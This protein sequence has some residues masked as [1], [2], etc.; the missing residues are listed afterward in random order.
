MVYET[1][2]V[3][4]E[5]KAFVWLQQFRRRMSTTQKFVARIAY[6]DVAAV[7]VAKLLRKYDFEIGDYDNY[8]TSAKNNRIFAIASVERAYDEGGIKRVD[9]LLY[10]LR[11]AWDGRAAALDRNI[12]KGL[13]KFMAGNAYG[14][15]V[16]AERLKDMD[17]YTLEV[18]A[19][20]VGHSR[21]LNTSDA[22][23]AVIG[24]LYNKKNL[25]AR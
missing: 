22:F 4:T 12:I 16:L 8:N 24:N 23:A 21:G 25:K 10:V 3:E 6:G 17:P 18:A 11:E 19:R 20:N 14:K 15:T 5:A 1:D 9:D 13:A 2:S 7:S